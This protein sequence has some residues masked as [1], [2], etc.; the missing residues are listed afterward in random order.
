MVVWRFSIGDLHTERRNR[1]GDC[2]YYG[3]RIGARMFEQRGETCP[4]HWCSL[5]GVCN[6]GPCFQPPYAE[7]DKVGSRA[8][9][10]S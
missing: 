8:L 6:D 5:E 2:C 9:L 7:S 4:P 1:Y 10:S 3:H